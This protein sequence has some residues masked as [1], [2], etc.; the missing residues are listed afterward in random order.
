MEY[1]EQDY[2]VDTYFAGCEHL[3]DEIY[4]YALKHKISNKLVD[5]EL[6]QKYFS[7]KK[8]RLGEKREY[9]LKVRLLDQVHSELEKMVG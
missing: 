8:R 9:G 3:L 2:L 1:I 5:N 6:H 7:G 4:D